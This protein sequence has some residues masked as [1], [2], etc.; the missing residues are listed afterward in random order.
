MPIFRQLAG[1]PPFSR[2]N[3]AG[4]NH[5]SPSQGYSSAFRLQ[6]SWQPTLLIRNTTAE[7]KKVLL[8]QKSMGENRQGPMC[9]P[10]ARYQVVC[11]R[12]FWLLEQKSAHVT[13]AT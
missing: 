4:S 9:K 5:L 7:T 6:T 12:T 1:Q 10:F 2:R 13:P 8:K 3:S 11:M